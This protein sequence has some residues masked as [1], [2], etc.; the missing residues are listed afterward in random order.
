MAARK[1]RIVLSDD[2]KERIRAGVLMQRLLA[3]VQGEVELSST[4]VKAA[5]I[6][7][8]K[9]VPDLNRTEQKLDITIEHIDQVIGK[10][11]SELGPIDLEAIDVVEEEGDEE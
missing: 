1:T 2:W 10:L 11:E 4:Q 5:D 3:H 8:K 6:L 9:I 7:L